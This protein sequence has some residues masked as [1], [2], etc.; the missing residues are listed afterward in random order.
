[1]EKRHFSF[2]ANIYNNIVYRLN[3]TITFNR[4][5]NTDVPSY[6]IQVDLTKLC[7]LLKFIT[8]CY[9]RIS[10]YECLCIP[11]YHIMGTYTYNNVE[12]IISAGMFSS[13]T[14]GFTDTYYNNYNN[15]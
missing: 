5:S 1:M 8:A 10:L 6:Q 14:Y 13:A 11:Y 2:S 3:I 12:Q 15:M 7:K 9:N 4:A